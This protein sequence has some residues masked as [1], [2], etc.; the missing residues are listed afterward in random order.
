MRN[1]ISELNECGNLRVD[2]KIAPELPYTYPY[3][4]R[5]VSSTDRIYTMTT[6]V[7]WKTMDRNRIVGFTPMRMSIGFDYFHD[8]INT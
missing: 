6:F 7:S 2:V 5:S 8:R 4:N 1:R 3:V